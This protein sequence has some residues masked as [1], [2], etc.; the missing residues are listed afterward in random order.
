MATI[1]LSHY[2]VDFLARQSVKHVFML[3]GGGAMHLN[4]SLGRC[5]GLHYVSNLHEQAA[6]A[7]AA[8]AHTPALRT[9]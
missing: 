5:A 9:G 8:E 2:V 3:A 4:D 6:V 1:K 7:I